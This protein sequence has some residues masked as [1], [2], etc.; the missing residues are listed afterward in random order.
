MKIAYVVMGNIW[1]I[2]LF[3]LMIGKTAS[4]AIIDPKMYSFFGTS[5]LHSSIVYTG[6]EG[7]CLFIAAANFWL[8]YFTKGK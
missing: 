8:A 4:T 7:M 2:I 6:L 1:L 5:Q 3:I